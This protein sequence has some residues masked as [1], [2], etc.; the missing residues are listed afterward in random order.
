MLRVRKLQLFGGLL[1]PLAGCASGN[2]PAALPT[3]H[4]A[5][6]NAAEAP[7]SVSGTLT[8][9]AGRQ[10]GD[11]SPNT[12]PANTPADASAGHGDH[13]SSAKS[14]A[15]SAATRP[16]TTHQAAYGCPMHPD[17]VSDKP[18][19][20]PKCGMSLTPAGGTQ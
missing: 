12:P 13:G 8:A 4:P 1:L 20:C 15:G 16:G 11:S 5:S 2:E 10:P 3:D 6:P 17:V 18:G 19:K 9:E 14:G 7:A